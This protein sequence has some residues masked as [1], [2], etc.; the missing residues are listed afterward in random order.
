MASTAHQSP[1]VEQN[2]REA[3]LNETIAVITRGGEASVRI[4]EVARA[5]GVT[6]GMI[7]YYFRDR[8]GLIA[9]A[10][11]ARYADVIDADLDVI[12][13]ISTNSSSPTDFKSRMSKLVRHLLTEERHPNRQL[14]AS[15]L[16][17][18]IGRPQ[19]LERIISAQS[20][21]IDHIAEALRVAQKRGVIRADIHP[22]GIAEFVTAYIIGMVVVD[23]DPKQTTLKVKSATFDLFLDSLLP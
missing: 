11:I 2:H 21:A 3:I 12:M 20:G 18:A 15:V 14:R 23:L 5:A 4:T 16:G 8:E 6:Q 10:Q 9:E 7:S 19:M 1:Q 13:N 22:R 17:S